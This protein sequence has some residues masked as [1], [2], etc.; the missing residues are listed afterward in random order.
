MYGDRDYYERLSESYKYISVVHKKLILLFLYLYH[1]SVFLRLSICHCQIAVTYLEF[2]D[3]ESVQRVSTEFE[4]SQSQALLSIC[5]HPEFENPK[6]RIVNLYS[7]KILNNKQNKWLMTV[8]III[9]L[10]IDDYDYYYLK[11]FY[12]LISAILRYLLF[13]FIAT[14]YCWWAGVRGERVGAAADAHAD[15]V[16]HFSPSAAQVE[17]NS[18]LSDWLVD[19]VEDF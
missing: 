16:L 8:S 9:T 2:R 13:L 7:S 15:D 18:G 1:T 3:D 6:Y 11:S 10:M 4:L 5:L 19:V 12:L 17:L 14:S